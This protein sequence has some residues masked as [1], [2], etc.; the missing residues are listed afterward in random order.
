MRYADKVWLGVWRP[1]AFARFK[2]SRFGLL[3]WHSPCAQATRFTFD[4]GRA[5]I[6]RGYGPPRG[7]PAPT[8]PDPSDWRP[9]SSQDRARGGDPTGCWL[10]STS[11]GRW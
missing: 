5:V 10:M 2:R 4:E 3:V 6:Y 7:D 1:R 11:D 9:A 8:S